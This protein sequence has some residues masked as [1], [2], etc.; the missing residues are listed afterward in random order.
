MLTTRVIVGVNFAIFVLATA[1]SF[2]A[3][4]LPRYDVERSCDQL[5]RAGGGYSEVVRGSCLDMEQA[6][7]DAL[8]PVWPDLP[9]GLKTSCQQIAG[10]PGSQSY[11]VLQSCLDMETEAAAANSGRR[12][13][14]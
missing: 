5:A 14:Y 4:T 11:T 9:A 6:S 7:Y 12:F 3:D 1:P 13:R 2:A 10:I 8:R